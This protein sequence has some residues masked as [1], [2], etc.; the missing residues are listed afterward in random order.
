MI[1]HKSGGSRNIKFDL[2]LNALYV[3]RSLN[4]LTALQ[5]TELHA[6]PIS[7]FP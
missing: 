5:F 3:V 4:F 2:R 7:T 1:I 6:A